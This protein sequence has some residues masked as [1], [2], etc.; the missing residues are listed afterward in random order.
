MIAYLARPKKFFSNYFFI[1]VFLRIIKPIQKATKVAPSI[2]NGSSN[3]SGGGIFDVKSFSKTH[4]PVSM[5]II[6]FCF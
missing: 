3:Q 2:G 1:C 4:R 5:V 6:M